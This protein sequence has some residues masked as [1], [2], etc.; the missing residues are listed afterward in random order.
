VSHVIHY[1]CDLCGKPIIPHQLNY[2]YDNPKP[3]VII[4]GQKG[5]DGFGT[6]TAPEC[7]GDCCKRV[8]GFLD[9]IKAENG[10]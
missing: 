2:G 8:W 10:I 5:T 3:I 6:K 7:C 4:V 9:L 1:K